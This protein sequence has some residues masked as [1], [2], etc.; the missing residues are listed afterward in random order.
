MYHDV[1]TLLVPNMYISINVSVY[2]AHSPLVQLVFVWGGA[3]VWSLFYLVSRTDI[4]PVCVS[5]TGSLFSSLD[6]QH[7][8]LIM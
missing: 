6:T 7:S 5:V 8:M 2:V 1:G 3:R 4:V